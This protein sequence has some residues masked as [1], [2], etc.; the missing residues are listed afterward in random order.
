MMVIDAPY[1]FHYKNIN[2][3]GILLRK[4]LNYFGFADKWCA[5]NY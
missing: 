4:H 3:P 2:F 5:V 1:V